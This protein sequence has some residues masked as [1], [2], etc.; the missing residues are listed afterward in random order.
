MRAMDTAAPRISW[1]WVAITALAMTVT[2]ALTYP[3]GFAAQF[4]AVLLV[5]M[6]FVVGLLWRRK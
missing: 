6:G 1:W 5:L 2:T 4:V 3:L